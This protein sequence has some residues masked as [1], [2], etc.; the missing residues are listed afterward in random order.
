MALCEEW[1]AVKGYEGLYEVSNL[2]RVRSLFRY[3]QIVKGVPTNRGYLRVT[4]CKDKVHKLCSVHRLVA[5]AFIQN[6]HNYPCVNHKDEVRTNNQANNLEWCSY[7]YNANY[8]HIVEKKKKNRDYSSISRE[9]EQIYD[10]KIIKIFPSITEAAKSVSN[11]RYAKTNICRVCNCVNKHAK[12]YG[13]EW[14]YK[15]EV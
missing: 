8:G 4:L 12:A 10:G 1:R 15:E 14:R 3:K 6:P 11:N 5:T 9:V 7:K 2:G 13:Y